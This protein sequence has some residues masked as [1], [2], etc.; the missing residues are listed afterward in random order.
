MLII[1]CMWGAVCVRTEAGSPCSSQGPLCDASPE[2]QLD[3]VLMQYAAFLALVPRAAVLVMQGIYGLERNWDTGGDLLGNTV[4]LETLAVFRRAEAVLAPRHHK[5]WRLQMLLWRAYYD[6]FLY[7]RLQQ[8]RAAEARARDL[9]TGG[10]TPPLLDAALKVLAPG[11]PADGCGAAAD[12]CG[13]AA[14]AEVVHLYARLT[15]LAGMLF[16]LCGLQLTTDYGGQHCQRGACF[17]LAWSAL[18]LLLLWSSG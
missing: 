6:A 7:R 12:T 8:E 9:L 4:V 14:K 15:A 10:L 5:S 11:D 1:V 17:D 16:V 3:A 13:D 2:Q 18:A